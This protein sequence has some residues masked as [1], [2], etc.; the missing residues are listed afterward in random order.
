MS[1]HLLTF[2][3]FSQSLQD[4]SDEVF[5]VLDEKDHLKYANFLGDLRS[6]DKE[7]LYEYVSNS[8]FDHLIRDLKDIDQGRREFFLIHLLQKSIANKRMS[9]LINRK[10]VLLRATIQKILTIIL[11]TKTTWLI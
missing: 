1:T 7:N 5:I 2:D 4:R 11:L 10:P 9:R 8:Y 6:I 3:Y